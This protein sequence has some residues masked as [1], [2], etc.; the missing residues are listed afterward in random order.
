M[1]YILLMLVVSMAFYNGAND[2]S[3]GVATLC[4]SGLCG[5]RTAL[6]WGAVW[7]VAGGVAAFF[8]ASGLSTFVVGEILNVNGGAVLIG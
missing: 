2:V 3:K 8:L 4:G 5:Y 1:D 7:T 6:S